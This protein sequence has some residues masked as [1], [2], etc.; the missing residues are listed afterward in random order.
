V[1][2]TDNVFLSEKNE[3]DDYITSVSA[4]FTAALLGKTSGLE[5]SYDPSY[6]FYDE[7]D[8]KD[9]WRHRANLFAWSDLTKRTRLE[10]IDSFLR[11]EDPL[12][13]EDLIREGDVIIE[14]DTTVRRTREQYYT[15]TAIARLSNQFGVDDLV[16]AEFLYSILRNDDPEVQDNDRYQPSIGLNYWFGPKFGIETRGVY[17]RGEFDRDSDFTDTPTDDFDDWAGSIRLI[18]RTTRHFSLFGQ[19]NH[20]YRNYDGDLDDDYM[21]YAPSAGFLYMIEEGLSLTLGLGYFYQDNDED[22]DEDG[23]FINGQ[24][25]KIWDFRRGFISLIGATGLDQNDFGAQ[26]LGL[27]RFASIQSAASYDFTREFSGGVSGSYRYSDVINSGGADDIESQHRYNLGAGLAYLPLKWMALRLD[28][29]FN[30]LDQQDGD[31]YDE[32]RV[33][34]SLTLQPD[35]PWKF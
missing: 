5:I 12:G 34:F 18:R 1:E 11:T 17:T 33:F 7:F 10:L 2:Y 24:I 32:N 8:E 16:Y 35:Q 14:G 21:V 4:G 20:I 27:E 26:N 3:E 6:V 9:G 25:N 13:E 23:A 28:Y 22:D 29:Q 30:K 15:N 19:Y 31:N